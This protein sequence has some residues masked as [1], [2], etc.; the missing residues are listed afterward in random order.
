MFNKIASTCGSTNRSKE[1]PFLVKSSASKSFKKLGFR[2]GDGNLV[3]QLASVVTLVLG[4]SVE[5]DQTLFWKCTYF[6]KLM[7]LNDDTETNYLCRKDG[8]KKGV[9]KYRCH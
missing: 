1:I 7:L 2:A 8:G 4:Y 3:N 5:G 9:K 6:I